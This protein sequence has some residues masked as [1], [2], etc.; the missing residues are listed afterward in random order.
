MGHTNLQP[1]PI[2]E[3]LEVFFEQV[4]RGA[5]AAATVTQHQQPFRLGMRRAPRVLPPQAMLSQHSALVSWLV[6]RWMCACWFHHVIDAMGNQLPLACGAKIV[7]KGF[8]RLGG[9]GRARR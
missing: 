8:H 5:V 4:L 7:V 9:E 2:G 1:Q 6:L 3:P